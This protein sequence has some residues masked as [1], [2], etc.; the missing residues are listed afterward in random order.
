MKKLVLIIAICIS[1][2]LFINGCTGYNAVMYDHLSNPDNYVEFSCTVEGVS[3]V[4]PS[5]NGYMER[6][7]AEHPTDVLQIDFTLCGWDYPMAL[8]VTSVSP[9]G[10]KADG[11]FELAYDS[12]IEL[13]NN[14]FF[15]SLEYGKEITV[16]SSLLTYM[17]TRFYYVAEVI[18]DGVTYL[19]FD[20]GLNNI[21]KIM[22]ENRSVL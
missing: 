11:S 22:D 21:V 5:E 1:T 19:D 8:F 12:I 20:T 16:R 10:S 13:C 14:G 6:L 18:M 4:Q 3:Y 15:E 7:Y 2:L 17:D 9:D